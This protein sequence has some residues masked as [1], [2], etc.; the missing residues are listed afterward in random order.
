MN[1]LEG[2]KVKSNQSKRTF[3]IRTSGGNKYRTLAMSQDDFDSAEMWTQQDWRQ[4]L[5]TDEYYVV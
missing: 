1:K 4:F 2:I 3:T 5:K